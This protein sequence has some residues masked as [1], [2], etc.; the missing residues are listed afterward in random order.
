MALTR[1]PRPVHADA[2]DPVRLFTPALAAPYGAAWGIARRLAPDEML[3]MAPLPWASIGSAAAR[4][5]CQTL[6]R[7][8][9]RTWSHSSSVHFDSDLVS[10]P[11][12]LLTRMSS[13]PSSASVVSTSCRH[14]S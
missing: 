11:P 10:A 7:L 5:R 6:P 13:R 1:T 2:M 3:T 4:E 14:A 9:A 12:A 8:R